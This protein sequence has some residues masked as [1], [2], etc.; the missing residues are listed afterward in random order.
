VADGAALRAKNL[1]LIFDQIKQYVIKWLKDNGLKLVL[2]IAGALAAIVAAEILTGG[3]ITAALPAIMTFVVQLMN[4]KA[5]VDVMEAL[6]KAG[7]YIGIYL[8]EGWP[9]KRAVC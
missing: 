9:R 7:G 3:A 2:G 1:G 8:T 5:L 4:A 6:G